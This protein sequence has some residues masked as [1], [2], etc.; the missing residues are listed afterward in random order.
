M[1]CSHCGKAYSQE[2]I[3]QKKK[4]K[5]VRISEARR[6]AKAN[7]EQVG[8]SRVFD[9]EK[10]LELRKKGLSVRKI[11]GIMGCSTSP[12]QDALKESSK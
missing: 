1:K 8:A 9:R 4:Q 7:G 2:E 3:A 11:A 6:L 10:I 12:V 5:S